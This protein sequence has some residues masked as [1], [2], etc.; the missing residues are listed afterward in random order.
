MR[1]LLLW[2]LA[3]ATAAQVNQPTPATIPSHESGS[4]R[5]D[6]QADRTTVQAGQPVWVTFTLTN[7][8]DKTVA[9]KV[10]DVPAVENTS[11]ESGLPLSHVFSGLRHS[12]VSI[13]DSHGDDWDS[14]VTHRPPDSAPLIRLAPHG[15]VGLRLD[16]TQY[17]PS[18]KRPGQYTLVWQPY[19]AAVESA[20]LTLSIL[21]ERQAVIL[22]EFGK[23]TVRFYYDQ[24]PNT[25]QNFIE[26][27][28]QRFYDRLIF[29]KVVPHLLIQGGS[30]GGDGRGCRTDGKRIKAE[31]SS[32]PF[33]KGTM[34]MA[35]LPSDPNSASSQFFITL[36]RLPSL[37]GNYTAF[38][39]LVGEESFRTLDKIASVPTDENNR[40]RQP[41]AIRAITLENVP[42]REPDMGVPN[43]L[44][45]PPA[46]RPAIM[47]DTAPGLSSLGAPD[48][49]RQ[50]A[51][52]AG[53]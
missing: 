2:V 41:V 9:L 40:P 12:G 46:T 43:S 17:Y 1:I 14:Q 21:A 8:T 27:V 39:Y 36:S 19:A 42:G 15:S 25:V 20:P 3:A 5:A 10:P 48:P 37:D 53:G 26:L 38:G 28:E 24:A 32:I 22:T 7:L 47:N 23:M 35:R 33:E 13:K 29:H 34:G 49:A 6:L 11:A 4:I 50:P 52:G 31:F 30:P 16:L 45:R 51:P 44:N 18:M